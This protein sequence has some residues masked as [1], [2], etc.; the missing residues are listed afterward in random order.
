MEDSD[1]HHGVEKNIVNSVKTFMEKQ[2]DVERG[3]VI[4]NVPMSLVRFTKETFVTS[5]FAR[6]AR[7]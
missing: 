4:L 2:H 5:D 1:T 7:F 6:E 3:T